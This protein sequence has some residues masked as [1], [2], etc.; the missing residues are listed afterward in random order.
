MSTVGQLER[1]TQNRVIR[2][3]RDTLHYAYLG[4]WEDRAGNSN[5][6]EA[7]L[8][9]V[10]TR[11]GVT[12]DLIERALTELRRAAGDQSKSLYD[13]NRAVYNLLR[14]GVQV[15]PDVGDVTQTV[16]LINWVHP[17]DNHFAV[18]EEVTVEGPNTKRPDV[19]LYVNGIALGVLELK[20]SVVSVAQGIRQNLA[21]QTKAFIE[22]FF[23]TVQLVM[24][25]SDTEGLRYGVIETPET[26][27]LTWK[28]EDDPGTIE[29]PLDRA[30]VRLCDKARF[31]EIVHD[32]LVYDA[33]T[34]KICRHNQYFAVKAAQAR[35]RRREDGHRQSADGHRQSADGIIW[36]TQGSGKS[37]IMVWLAKWIREHVPDARVLIITDRTE[38]DEQIEKVFLG[39]DE[40]IVR[41]TSGRDLIARLN[42]PEH[43]L[44][45]SLIHKFGAREEGDVDRY[46]DEVRRSLPPG[47]SAKGE[48]FVYVDECHRTQSGKLHRAMK[49]ILPDAMFIG[50]TGTPL[51]KQDKSTSLEVFGPYIHT[52]KYDEAVRD[53]VVLDLRY[54]A[55]DVDQAL[56]SQKKIDQWFAAKTKGLTDVALAELKKRWGTMQRVLSSRSRLEQIVGDIMLDMETRDRLQSG[57]GNALLVSDSIYNACKF[58]ELFVQAGLKRCA[59]VTSYKPTPA[60]IK[61]EET[62]EG[63]TE[64]LRQYEIYRRMLADWFEQDEDA[65]MVRID[66]FERE[67]KAKFVHEP[68]QMKLLIVVDKLLTGF[69]APPATYLYIDKPMRDHG[70]FQAICRVNRL[71][72]EDKE[73]GYVVDYRDLFKSLE[74]SVHDYTSEAFEGYDKED[75]EG[76]LT[77]RLEKARERLAETREAVK[78]LCEPVAPSRSTE[79]YLAYF[80]AEDTS[81]KEALKENERKRVTLYKAV[82]AFVRAYANLAN[83]MDE[84]GLNPA[85]AAAVKAEVTHYERVRSEVKLASGDYIDLKAYEPA[86]RHLIDTYI[87]ADESEVL[88]TFD[89]MTL[90]ELIVERGVGAVDALPEGIKESQEA[91]A[92]TIENNVRKL[93]IDEQPLNPK[94]Y[95]RMSDLLD[96]LIAARR[97]KAIAYEAYLAEIAELAKQVKQPGTGAT[98]PKAVDTQARRAL[99]DNLDGDAELALAVDHEIRTTKKDGWRGNRIKEKEVRYAIKR[100]LDDEAQVDRIFDLAVHQHEY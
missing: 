61:L 32:F 60:D 34:K 17:E 10:L 97:A 65:A 55:R 45:C 51:L 22:P 100:H 89:D 74:K 24:A 70:L 92:E 26:Y 98:Y 47:F 41:T 58:Y 18:A 6:E 53:G 31:L 27:Y 39:V 42:S 8:R 76:L 64:A 23:A 5:I 73:Y 68:G 7:L 62:G 9:K 2:R 29:N 30:L 15:R 46:I 4:N 84:A 78:V 82:A 80:C 38:L 75:V 71:N 96:Q 35:I 83:E 63:Y 77:D 56:T 90:V 20:R 99:Y 37:L 79:A 66:E 69:D 43:W 85:E 33:G 40:Q 19:V 49:A 91:V 81:D 88:S 86:M 94:Y 44:I 72:G 21:N 25:G 48:L 52:Y 57:H 93:I 54:E 36:H 11:R 87:R 13:R 95:D 16:H 59:I 12:P 1:R 14:Y 50:F 28:E 67:V 3:L